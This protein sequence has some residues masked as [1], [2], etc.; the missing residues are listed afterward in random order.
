MKSTINLER[1]EGTV[2]RVMH[3]EIG[4]SFAMLDE[5]YLKG[6]YVLC[7]CLEPRHCDRNDDLCTA[8][9]DIKPGHIRKDRDVFVSEGIGKFS[10]TV[11]QASQKRK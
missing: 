1:L 11:G 4:F 2:T 10:V 8:A 7:N 5:L 3:K 6:S 9:T